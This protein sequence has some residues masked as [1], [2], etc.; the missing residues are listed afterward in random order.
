MTPQHISLLDDFVIG[1]VFSFFLGQV[2][3]PFLGQVANPFYHISTILTMFSQSAWHLQVP[4]TS[5]DEAILTMG[6]LYCATGATS[7]P[8]VSNRA[9]CPGSTLSSVCSSR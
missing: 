6:R 9:K 5:G 8:D 3:N 4:G 1:Q 2:A 7:R